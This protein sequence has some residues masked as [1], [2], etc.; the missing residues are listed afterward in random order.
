MNCIDKY[1]IHRK[2]LKTGMIFL[3]VAETVA[4]KAVNHTD[5]SYVHHSGVIIEF[6][7][8]IM[9]LDKQPNRDGLS[10]LSQRIREKKYTDF[11]VLEPQFPQEDVLRAVRNT[12]VRAESFIHYNKKILFAI[13]FYQKTGLW[14]GDIE[15]GDDVCSF[16]TQ[17]YAIEAGSIR[18]KQENVE[19]PF[20]LPQDHLRYLHLEEF[21]IFID[22][23]Y[24][25]Y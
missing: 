24:T 13:W 16:L 15:E 1:K 18:L 22:A 20:F 17:Y 11:L 8:R 7:G 6:M 19:R 4:A 12:M 3:A 23:G 5:D 25:S 9:I 2:D 21:K 10:F 14:I